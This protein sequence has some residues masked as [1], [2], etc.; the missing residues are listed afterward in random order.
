MSDC[1]QES[2]IA[3]AVA[4]GSL[5][6]DLLL[7]VAG[8]PVCREAHS[9]AGKMRH[10]ANGLSE[11][12]RPSATSMWWRLNLRMRRERAN[13]A[14]KPLVWM[15]RILYASIPLTVGLELTFI[16]GLSG[17]VAVIGVAALGAVVLP[18]A[19]A[20]AGWFVWRSD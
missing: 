7:H 6:Q 14:E 4:N 15:S 3:T 17:R 5:P 19:I 11:D 10:F 2:R 1:P 16:P 20:L 18:V 12:P 13:H 9:I 8:C